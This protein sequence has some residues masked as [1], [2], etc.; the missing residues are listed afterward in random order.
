MKVVTSFF[1]ALILSA[2]VAG[3]ASAMTATAKVLPK[4]EKSS[5]TEMTHRH[6]V[7]K[8]HRVKAH[9]KAAVRKVANHNAGSK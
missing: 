3:G 9:K 2:F 6:K 5:K 4:T 7:R 1:C 8:H